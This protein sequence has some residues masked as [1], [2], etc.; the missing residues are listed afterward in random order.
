MIQLLALLALSQAPTTTTT[1]PPVKQPDKISVA[2]MDLAAEG[3]SKQLTA[4]LAG[5][6]TDA[7]D[8][9]GPFDALSSQDIQRML[10]FESAKQTLG[11]SADVSCL[12]EIASSM[13]VSYLVTGRLSRIDDQ[14]LMQLQL[15]EVGKAQVVARESR[16]YDAKLP[17]SGLMELGGSAAKA[18][19]RELLLTR[20]GSVEIRASESDATVRI[21]ERIVGVT[22]LPRLDVGGGVHKVS[23]E[24]EGFVTAAKDVE[25]RQGE[26]SVVDIKLLPSTEYRERYQGNANLV[27]IASWSGVG[28]GVVGVGAA[29][30]LFVVGGNMATDLS[31]R[32]DDY[33]ASAVKDEA[34]HDALVKDAAAIGTVDALVLVAAGV[35]VVAAGAGVVGLV[36]GPD[37]GRY[38]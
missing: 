22:P 18:L 14:Y 17:V 32:I 35:G 30:A 33:N 16:D 1:T 20:A 23:I 6:M 37:P 34:A 36:A 5:S 27:R 2:V 19:V 10:E 21:D 28:V 7:L 29:V 25:I 13:G 4:A 15:V 24:K 38:E 26:T 11:C 31:G 12:A 3:L 9:L 8:A